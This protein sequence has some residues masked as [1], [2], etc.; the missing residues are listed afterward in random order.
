MVD[1]NKAGAEATAA[2]LNQA[3]AEEGDGGTGPRA[4]VAVVDISDEAAVSALFDQVQGSEGRLDVLVNNA[5]RFVL[6]SAEAATAED[7]DTVLGSNL[8]GYGLV[9][10]HAIRVMKATKTRGSATESCTSF[11]G[12]CV[13]GLCPSFLF[14][15][16]PSTHPSFLRNAAGCSIVNLGSISSFVGQPGMCTYSATKAAI[17]ALT[18]CTAIDC[19]PYG[20][21]VNAIC[22]GPI[23]TDATRRHA[24]SQVRCDL[25]GCVMCVPL[26]SFPPC[27]LCSTPPS[28]QKRAKPTRTWWQN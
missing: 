7:W 23:L 2:A 17:L 8:K 14:F 21:R 22:P 26:K 6:K 1:V 28:L 11:F 12:V 19:G 27:P 10:K 16:H 25:G 20:I 15:T 24:E 9:S 4:V 18:R 5:A 13:W 3:Q